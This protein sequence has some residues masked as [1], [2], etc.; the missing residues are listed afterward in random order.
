M[1]AT[2]S[3]FVEAPR[4]HAWAGTGQVFKRSLTPSSQTADYPNICDIPFIKGY[5]AESRQ[6]KRFIGGLI[7]GILSSI[8]TMTLFGL[9]ERAK[10]DELGQAL[11][12]TQTRQQAMIH[13]LDANSKDIQ[14]NGLAIE[15]LTAAVEG[16]AK[17]VEMNHLGP[18]NAYNC[19]CCQE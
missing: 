6:P 15:T 18:K 13:L 4:R 16:I 10:I 12:T 3:T 11:H 19:N 2:D 14:T 8:G 17:V 7:A 1:P 9:V 5:Q